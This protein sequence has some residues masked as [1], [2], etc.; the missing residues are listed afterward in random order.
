MARLAL[1]RSLWLV[2]SALAVAAFV[3]LGWR[4]QVRELP[5]LPEAP[6]PQAEYYLRD[7]MVDV[8]DENGNLSYRMKTAELL[9]FSDHSSQ[10]SDVEIESLGGTQGVWRLEAGKARLGE[11]QEVMQLSGGVN[12]QS[13]GPRGST[14]LTTRTLKVELKKN[15]LDTHDAVSI[16]G[17]D[18]EAQAVGMQSAFDSRNM[19]LLNKVRT[20]Y[21]P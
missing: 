17:P 16:V 6:P 20:R 3:T 11:D 21:V 7:A 8:M 9:R 10:M 13:Q 4:T 12:M 5:A 18:F 19:V 15:R 1:S 14:R 2:L